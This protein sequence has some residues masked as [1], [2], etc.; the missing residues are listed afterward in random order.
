[1][2]KTSFKC[3]LPDIFDHLDKQNQYYEIFYLQSATQSIMKFNVIGSLAL[4]GALA[5]AAPIGNT[6]STESH[7]SEGCKLT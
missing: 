1:M 4:L 6:V 3:L 5:Q 7:D 2:Y